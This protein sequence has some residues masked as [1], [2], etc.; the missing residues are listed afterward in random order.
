MWKDP[1][2]EELQQQRDEY[3][4]QFNYDLK[5]MFEDVKAQERQ[6]TT[7]P[8]VSLSAQKRVVEELRNGRNSVS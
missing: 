1:I 6:N 4:K 2:I 7:N 8:I 3:A 5:A